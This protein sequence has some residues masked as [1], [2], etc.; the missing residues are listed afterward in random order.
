MASFNEF[1]RYYERGKCMSKDIKGD[2]IESRRRQHYR[3]FP[4][5]LD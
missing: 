2:I 3:I 5:Q 1:G 4:W